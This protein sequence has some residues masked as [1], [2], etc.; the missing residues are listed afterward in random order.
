MTMSEE[1]KHYQKLLDIAREPVESSNVMSIG[2]SKLYRVVQ[3]EFHKEGKSLGVY[4][5]GDCDEQMYKDLKAAESKGEFVNKY[6][7]KTHKPY[8][9]VA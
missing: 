7:K 2:Y 9:K 4:Q 1:I 8:A 3:I 6:L 5:Y